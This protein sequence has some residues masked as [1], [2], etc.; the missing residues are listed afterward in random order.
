MRTFSAR[1]IVPLAVLL[2]SGLLACSDSDRGL[3]GDD[4][5][6][7]VSFALSGTVGDAPGLPEE[8]QLTLE[9]HG[10]SGRHLPDGTLVTMETTNWTFDNGLRQVTVE[11]LGGRAVAL[12][13]VD[14]SGSASVTATFAVDGKRISASTTIAVTVEGKASLVT[15]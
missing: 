11:S 3:P 10:W 12:L 4:E 13:L 6:W 7:S 14:S 9:V 5:V 2:V 1:A 15:P 8:V